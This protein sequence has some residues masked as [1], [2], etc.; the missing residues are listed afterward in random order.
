MNQSNSRDPILSERTLLDA[1]QDPLKDRCAV[2]H[3]PGE[4]SPDNSSA[5]ST[6]GETTRGN[7]IRTR[8]AH[9][10]DRRSST[11]HWKNDYNHEP[12]NCWRGLRPCYPLS[13]E[14]SATL[15]HNY[16]LVIKTSAVT[17]SNSG[18][19]RCDTAVTP[20]PSSRS[21]RCAHPDRCAFR[22]HEPG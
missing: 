13:T 17:S 2:A 1:W 7:G 9:A 18:H 11:S 8:P 6:S 3:A 22:A 12:L 16:K 21:S 20:V 4:N 19:H 10:H 5:C 14:A 15:V